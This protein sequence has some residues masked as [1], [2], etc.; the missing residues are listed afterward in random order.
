[1]IDDLL[2][3]NCRLY[4]VY[5]TQPSTFVS[6]YFEQYSVQHVRAGKIPLLYLPEFQAVAADIIDTDVTDEES[7]VNYVSGHALLVTRHVSVSD[8]GTI[9]WNRHE[10]AV[11]QKISALVNYEAPAHG[12]NSCKGV[13]PNIKSTSQISPIYYKYRYYQ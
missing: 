1:M 7:S 12:Q 6:Q 4:V 5:S 3:L 13:P 10:S 9:D 11:H 2:V 8:L